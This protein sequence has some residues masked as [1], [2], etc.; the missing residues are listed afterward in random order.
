MINDYKLP[1]KY[2]QTKFMK[3]IIYM[4]MLLNIQSLLI[5]NIKLV[6]VVM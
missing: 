2:Y 4:S 6:S 1:D 5:K 3:Y